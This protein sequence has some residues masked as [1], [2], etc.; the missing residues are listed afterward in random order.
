MADDYNENRL[1]IPDP[2]PLTTAQLHREIEA[3]TTVFDT[4][5]IGNDK[6][7]S[8]LQQF[9]NSMP[10]PALVQA[11]VDALQLVVN[12]RFNS[13]ALQFQ[14][15]DVRTDQ[16]SRD[17]KVAV[18]AA[19][20]AAKEAVGEQN[21]SSALAIAKSESSTQ[22]QIDQQGVLIAT[23]T[24]ALN[25]KIVDMK[26]RLIRIEEGR[27]GV[28]EHKVDDQHRGS[29]QMQGVGLMVAIGVAILGLVGFLMAQSNSSSN[30]QRDVYVPSAPGMPPVVT[31]P[32][33][34][35]PLGMNP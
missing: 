4:R 31:T 12:E 32:P 5:L 18:D 11:S 25:D 9:A 15:R 26:G 14:E 2:T 20:Q 10:T 1:P 3:L 34:G 23:A 28:L 33:Q 30:E 16:T 7:I 6:A 8:I 27:A 19:L 29:N 35:N 13:I 22:K 21:K 24:A 17:S